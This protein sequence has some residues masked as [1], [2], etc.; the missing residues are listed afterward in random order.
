MNPGRASRGDHPPTRSSLSLFWGTELAVF[1]DV[2]GRECGRRLVDQVRSSRKDIRSLRAYE[3][4][5]E[6]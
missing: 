3:Y 5:E 6:Q 1:A 4:Q 2:G